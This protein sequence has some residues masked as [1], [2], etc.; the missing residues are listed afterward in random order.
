MWTIPIHINHFFKNVIDGITLIKTLADFDIFDTELA[1]GSK[2]KNIVIENVVKAFKYP[3]E[4][5]HGK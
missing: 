4:A 5:E 1:L 2:Y 3:K